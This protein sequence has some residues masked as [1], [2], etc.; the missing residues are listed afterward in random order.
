MKV[1]HKHAPRKKKLARGN[2]MPFMTKDLSKKTM[3][4]L[5]LRNRFLENKSLGNRMLYTQQRNYCVSLKKD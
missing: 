1:L 4:C 2:Q 3:K 5:R